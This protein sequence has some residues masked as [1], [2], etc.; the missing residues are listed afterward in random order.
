LNPRL[1]ASSGG[2]VRQEFEPPCEVPFQAILF[3]GTVPPYQKIANEAVRLRTLKLSLR[4]IGRH[5]GISKKTVL[6]ALRFRYRD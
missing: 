5:L 4:V 6:K 2:R 3:D 1:A